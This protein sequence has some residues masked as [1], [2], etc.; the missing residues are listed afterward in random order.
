MLN[1][2]RADGVG[3][4]GMLCT[5]SIC[6]RHISVLSVLHGCNV[7]VSTG[8]LTEVVHQ[9]QIQYTL[10]T[11]DLTASMFALVVSSK[12]VFQDILSQSSDPFVSGL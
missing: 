5:C 8:V 6:H 10:V 9:G 2:K 3:V 1:L 7:L 11:N 4:P 12:S